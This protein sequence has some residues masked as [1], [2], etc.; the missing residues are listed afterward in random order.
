MKDKM[1]KLEEELQRLMDLSQSKSNQ[2]REMDNKT[3]FDKQRGSMAL[4]KSVAYGHAIELVRQI[5]S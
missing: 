3:E 1:I 5:L 2:I 4:G